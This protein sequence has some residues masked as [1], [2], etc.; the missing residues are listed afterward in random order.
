MRDR[1][2]QMMKGF[3]QWK[4]II[5]MG[6]AASVVV[7]YDRINLSRITVKPAAHGLIR[8]N[9]RNEDNNCT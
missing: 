4:I 9:S 6:P 1:I 2:A 7:L 5:L 8:I 3:V